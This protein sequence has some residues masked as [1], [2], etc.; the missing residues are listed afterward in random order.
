MSEFIQGQRWLA[1]GEPELGL[2]VVQSVDARTVTLHFPSAEDQRC[3]ALREPPLTRIRFDIGDSIEKRDQGQVEV[4]A[5]HELKGLLVY[6]T[7]DGMV[8]E[9]ELAD[10]IDHDNPLTRLLTSQTDHPNWFAFRSA[11]SNGHQAIWNQHL[12]GLLGTRSSLLPH[13]LYV[14]YQ[15]TQQTRVRA[16]LSDEV[17]LGKTIE[18]GLIINRLRQQGRASRV[19]IAVPDALQAQWLVELVRR[20][21]IQPEFYQHSEHDFSLGQVHLVPHSLLA[22]EEEM[23][24]V[25]AADWD[26]LVVDEAHHLDMTPPT[27]ATAESSWLTIAQR[28]PHLLLLTAT[29]EQ[30]GQ[31]AHFERLQLLDA[32]RFASFEQYQADESHFLALSDLALALDQNKIDDDLI[33]QLQTLGIEWHDDRQRALNEVLDRHGPGRVVYR[34]TRRGVSGFHSRQVEAHP[35][36]TETQR[37]AWLVDWLKQHRDQKVLLIAQAAEVAQELA[38]SLWHE[39]G[40]EATAFHEGLNLIERDRA[41]AHFAS[42]EDGAQVLVCSEIGGEGRNFQFCH[43]LVLWDLPDHPDV[44]EQRIGRLDRIGQTDTVHIHLPYLIGSDEEHRFEWFH[45]VLDCVEQHQP[46]AGIV[47]AQHSETWLADPDDLILTE[48]IRDDLERLNAELEQGR[49]VMLELNSCRQPQADQLTDAI[50]ELEQHSALDVVEQAAN[51]L[52]LHFETISDGIFELIP[53]DKMLIPIIPGIP[54]GGA[55]V[56]FDRDT[57]LA[58]EDVHF[59]SWEHP[60]VL[61][62]LDLVSGS[63]LGQASVALL[64]TKQVPAGQLLLETQWRLAIPER[65]AHALKPHLN[66]GLLRTLTLEGGQSDLSQTLGQEVLQAQVKTLPVKTVRKLVQ[67][68]KERI[69]PIFDVA[70]GHA[71]SQFEQTLSQARRSLAATNQARVER[72]QYL[73]GVNPLVTEQD[74]TKAQMQAELL[75]AAWDSVELQPAGVRLILCAP[76]G[77]I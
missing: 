63:Q 57:A 28:S 76:P 39:Q 41:A 72:L 65:S 73:S 24:W 55:L 62:L 58:R 2:G 33:Q 46:A 50:T 12:N 47:H 5:V 48:Q 56:C 42:D 67:S 59:V 74:V 52:N 31:Q 29:P 4:V 26:M 1:D 30:L 54:E 9:S 11:L 38:H 34:N 51:L 22:N 60:L 19:L 49:D 75:D 45:E 35:A 44:L 7:A 53:S 77:S 13:Q 68:A 6:E 21:A 40:I 14:A 37:R 15:A 43:H 17:G 20:F 36:D 71:Q 3:Y 70:Q 16:L 27:E 8:P 10:H 64:E 18:A 61:G 32:S 69:S 25:T 66:E 23:T